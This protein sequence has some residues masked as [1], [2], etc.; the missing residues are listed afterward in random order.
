MSEELETIAQ[1]LGDAL[2][3]QGVMLATAESCT[4]GW[5]AQVLTSI[6]GSSNWFERG[7]VT[8]SN[9]AKH[10][11][12]GVR[13]QT[14]DKFGAVS[15]AVAREMAEGALLHSEADIA[16]SVT[17]IAGPDGGSAEKPVGLVWFAWAGRQFDTQARSQHCS[18]DR[19]AIRAQAVHYAL[20]ELLNILT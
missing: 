1:Q 18:G 13:A 11:L 4:G 3:K 14:I 19:A 6:P 12:L 7:V 8:Y 9:A 16:L 15:E 2:L 5:V 20:S 10:D 17:G